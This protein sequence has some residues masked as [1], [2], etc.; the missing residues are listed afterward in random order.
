MTIHRA[1]GSNHVIDFRERAPL[2]A[3]PTLFQDAAGNVLP[4]ASRRGYLAVAVPG[5]VAGLERAREAYGTQARAALMAPAIAL[6]ENGFLLDAGD[7]GP[8]GLWNCPFQHRAE[9]CRH[10]HA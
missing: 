3:T 8:L 2:R 5:T 9:R 6:A 10:L 7:T 4:D 1:D